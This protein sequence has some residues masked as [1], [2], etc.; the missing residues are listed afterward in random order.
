[1]GMTLGYILQ[2]SGGKQLLSRVQMSAGTAIAFA[3]AA[4]S[5]FG[6]SHSARRDYVYNASEAAI[7]GT[8]QPLMWSFALCWLVYCCATNQT[9]GLTFFDKYLHIQYFSIDF[10]SRKDCRQVHNNIAE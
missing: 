3:C 6:V 9:P 2:T 4:Y 8:L 10:W 7:F 5:L 1:M